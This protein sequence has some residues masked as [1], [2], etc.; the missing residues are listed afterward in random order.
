MPLTKIG[1]V[2][3]QMGISHR[4]L[5]YWENVGILKSSRAEND[6]RY[7]DGENLLKIKQIVLL[8]KLRLSIPSIH[9]IFASEKLSKIISV[10][11]NH[12]DET[13]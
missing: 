3:S 2:V 13:K 9:E 5:H 6:Y 11:A 7:Y 4:S 12:L 10:F 1:D 8:R